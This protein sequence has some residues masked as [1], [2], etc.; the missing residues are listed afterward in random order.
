MQDVRAERELKNELKEFMP[1]DIEWN[2]YR[3]TSDINFAGLPIDMKTV[4]RCKELVTEYEQIEI[5]RCKELTDGISPTQVAALTEWC[6]ERLNG[7]KLEDLTAGTVDKALANKDIPQEV[8]EPLAIRRSISR[9]SVKK[10]NPMIDCAGTDNRVRGTLIYHG[11]TTGRWTASL[12]QPHNLPKPTLKDSKTALWFIQNASLEDII[13]TFPDPMEVFSSCI[14]HFIAPKKGREL[15][16]ADYSSIEARVLCTIA[17]QKD[18]V[19][20]YWKDIESRNRYLNGEITEEQRDKE[21]WQLDPY[22]HMAAA[23][24]KVKILE[25]NKDQRDLGKQ[26]VLGC[27]Y[28]MG[29]ST[30]KKTCEGYGIYISKELADAAVKAYRKKYYMVVK[31]WEFVQNCALKCVVNKKTVECG[32]FEMSFRRGYFLIKLPSGRYLSYP[33]AKIEPVRTPWGDLRDAVTFFGHV[34]NNFWGRVSTYGGKLVENMVQAMARD[35][36]A[37]GMLQAEAAGYPPIGTVHDEG[38]TEVDEGTRSVREY[39]ALLCTVPEWAKDIPII[40]EGFRDT[41]YKK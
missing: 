18:A 3:M 30:F 31:L 7:S 8:K 13:F 33:E 32:E 15:I 20:L 28:N 14:R 23:I 27:G 39:E 37:Y 24:Y 9:T 21:K 10:I 2:I 17:G 41:R 12:M 11:A 34:E 29:G 40:A 36:M 1:P 22:V 38:I 6:N 5:E 4:K 19:D 25:I 16:V 26:D 35:I